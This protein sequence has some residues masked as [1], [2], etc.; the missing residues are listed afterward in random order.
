MDINFVPGSTW[1]SIPLPVDVFR[2]ILSKDTAQ[3]TFEECLYH[4]LGEIEGVYQVDYDGH[5]GSQIEVQIE[6]ELDTKFTRFEI[7]QTIKDYVENE[8][9]QRKHTALPAG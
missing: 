3:D 4:K 5:F 8:C 7:E 2:A 6:T 1:Y 9:S